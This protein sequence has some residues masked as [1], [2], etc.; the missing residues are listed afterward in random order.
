MMIGTHSH[1][2]IH[3]NRASLALGI[4][5]SIEHYEVTNLCCSSNTN[6]EIHL[7]T[8]RCSHSSLVVYDGDQKQAS[9]EHWVKSTGPMIYP[10][11]TQ[12]E[13]ES[14]H[15]ASKSVGH[16]NVCLFQ[17]KYALSSS[18]QRNIYFVFVVVHCALYSTTPNTF[19]S[20][21]T[22]SAT[23][24]LSIFPFLIFFDSWFLLLVHLTRSMKITLHKYPKNQPLNVTR[25]MSRV[26]AICE[27]HTQSHLT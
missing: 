15:S 25:W 10:L 23:G 13:C 20:R 9:K 21:R 1:P 24:S 4:H 8:C 18:T 19:N 11:H 7:F 27:L 17:L 3:L 2:F 22:S 6:A 14:A 26:G 16:P 12:T 5:A